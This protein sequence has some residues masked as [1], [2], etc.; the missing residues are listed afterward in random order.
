MIHFIKD[1]NDA[2][3][4]YH[5]GYMASNNIFTFHGQA[6]N[7]TKFTS[8]EHWFTVDYVGLF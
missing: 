5:K 2:K 8:G 4:T 7:I 3:Y 1:I 6:I